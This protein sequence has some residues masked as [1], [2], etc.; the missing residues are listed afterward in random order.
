MFKAGDIKAHFEIVGKL[1]PAKTHLFDQLIKKFGKKAAYSEDEVRAI[2]AP[3]I[4]K[5]DPLLKLLV[6]PPNSRIDAFPREEVRKHFELLKS[7]DPK[8]KASM[9]TLEKKYPGQD[10]YS[11]AQVRDVA[12]NGEQ[13]MTTAIRP[14]TPVTF[15]ANAEAAAGRSWFLDGWKT[16]LVRHDWIDLLSSE[17]LSITSGQKAKVDDLVG[18]TFSYARDND[19]GTD[20]WS[21]VGALIWPW[22]YDRPEVRSLLPQEIA[23]TPSVSVNRISTSGAPKTEV[24]QLF[25]RVGVFLQWSEPFPK[26]LDR[27]QLRGAPVFGTDTGFRARMP[28]YEF[29]LEP[30]SL[31]GN[32]KDEDCRYKL[33]FKNILWYKSPLLEDSSDQSVL[34]YQLRLWMHLEGGDIQDI[35]KSFATTPGSF[36]RLGPV[37][38]LRVNSFFPVPLLSKGLSFTAQYS[39]LPTIDGLTGHDYLLSLAAA[40]TIRD[41]KA[42]HQKLFVTG[43]YTNGGLNFTKQDVNTFTLGLSVLF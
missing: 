16:P 22:V 31:F 39:Y 4:P 43:S 30:S 10:F 36:F 7:V 19:A 23:I 2:E 6:Q 3:E 17:D 37:A 25:F 13:W 34:D 12:K 8:T 27:I 32:G 29:D 11:A 1:D 26:Y 38:Q 14:D 21:T 24:D 42:N 5:E 15:V 35:G 40:L 41:D 20:T 9:A 28:G 18:A 33:G